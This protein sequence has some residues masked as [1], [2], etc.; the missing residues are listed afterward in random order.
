MGYDSGMEKLSEQIRQ[1]I[2]ASG[3]S[4]YRICKET[5]IDQAAMSRF[6]AGTVGLTQENL[7]RVAAFLGLELRKRR[8]RKG[9]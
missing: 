4:R 9:R 7:D 8:G 2:D 5:G 3:Y 6:M 1:A